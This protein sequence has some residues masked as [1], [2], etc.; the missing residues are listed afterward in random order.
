MAEA[1]LRHRAGGIFDAHSAG[2]DPQGV[3]PFSV[4]ALQEIGVDTSGLRSKHLDEFQGRAAVDFLIAVCSAADRNCPVALFP[5]VR[6]LSWPFDDPAAVQGTDEDRLGAFRRVRNQ[7]DARITG[8]LKE[9]PWK[10][11]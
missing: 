6:R 9:E 1:L 11:S 8:W 10:P 2:T 4:R 3:N 7:I 5:G